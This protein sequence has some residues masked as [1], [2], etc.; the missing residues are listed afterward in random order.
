MDLMS[1][2][3]SVM[4]S[5]VIYLAIL[6]LALLDAFLPIVPSETVVIAAA[7]FAVS[8]I[9]SL[10]LI[11]VLAA[12]GA[13]IGDHVGYGL[14]HL[15]RKRGRDGRLARLAD[16]FAPHLHRRG[17]ALIIA[18]RFIPGGRTAVVTTSGAT[19]YPLAKFSLFTAIAAALWATYSG[20]IGYLGGAAFESNPALGLAMGIGLALSIT[21]LGELARWWWGR[22]RSRR[23][24]EPEAPALVGAG[25]RSE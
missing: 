2:L 9:P 25:S 4:T 8:G 6:V 24:P 23:M 11:I 10:P 22:R 20:L 21:G 7:V 3:E 16:K 17:G 19:G 13:F 1:W 5:P 15:V 12:V 18:A 14:G